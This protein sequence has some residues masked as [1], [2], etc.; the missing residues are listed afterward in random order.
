MFRGKQIL[1]ASVAAALALM[2][3]AHVSAEAINDPMQPPGREMAGRGKAGTP[4]AATRYR[5][6]SVIIAPNRRQAII[7]GQRLSLGES[8]GGSR[9]ID[10]QATQVTL[11]VGGKSHVLTLLPLSIKMPS[12][13]MRQ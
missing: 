5:L 9:L 12:E 1:L 8:I 11:L 2:G 10:V 4:A 6:D 13:A 7:N 3:A